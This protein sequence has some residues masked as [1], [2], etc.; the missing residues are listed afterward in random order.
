MVKV[1]VPVS[2]ARE[3]AQ[4]AQS[5]ARNIMYKRG[6]S[7]STANSL[8]TVSADGMVGLSSPVK[9]IF[10]QER[11]IRSFLMSELEGKRIPIGDRIVTAKDVGKPGFVR[12]PRKGGGP[13][14]VK[15]R[16]QKWRHP[17]IKPQ[18]ILK[19]SLSRAILEDTPHV[20]SEIARRLEGR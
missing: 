16:N 2:L 11:G 9:H 18:N 1:K 15:W 7:G 10:Y 4:R 14:I 8:S 17:G 3:T 5:H 6:W 13:D 20:R 12:I 19:D